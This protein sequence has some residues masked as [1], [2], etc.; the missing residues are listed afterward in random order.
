MEQASTAAPDELQQAINSI[1]SGGAA[2][3]A[4][5]V[6]AQVE[7]ATAAAEPAAAVAAA[8]VPVAPIESMKAQYGDPDLDK[9]KTAA[10]SDLRPL[11]E[12]VDI[13]AEKKFMIYKDILE[14][15]E[16]KACIEPAYNAASKIT[17]EKTKGEALV[18]I[19]EC[20]DK[21]GIQMAVGAEEEEEQ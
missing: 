13:P 19:V 17:D 12:K 16:D 3:G 18:F 21:L 8:A 2:T 11:L 4:A 15:T 9:V 20:I 7:A 10:L 5:D 14:L 6:T 1:T